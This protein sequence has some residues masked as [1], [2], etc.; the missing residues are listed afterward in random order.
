M[1]ALLQRVSEARVVAEG[2]VAGRIGKGLVIFLGVLKGDTD[3]DLEYIAKKIAGL[4]VFDDEN[5]KMNLSVLDTA[6]SILVVSQFTL[7]ADCRRGNRP[8]F[9]DAEE[10]ERAERMYLDLI[11]RLSGRGIAVESGRFAFHM[12]VQIVNDGPVTIL[13]DSRRDNFITPG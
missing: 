4:R 11:S 6:G 1:R 5:G 7:A 3:K 8:S 2:E 13:L 9:D 10:P 12:Y